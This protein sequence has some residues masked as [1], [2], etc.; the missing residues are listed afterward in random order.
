VTTRGIYRLPQVMAMLAASI[1]GGISVLSGISGQARAQGTLD[2]QYSIS[3]GGIPFGK[4]AWR[5]DVREDQFTATLSGATTGLLQLFAQGQGS[6]AVRGT[7]SK[8]EPRA[9]TYVSSIQTDKKYDE[10]RMVMN[11]NSV[12]E[13]QA[14]PPTPPSPSRIP[15]T[16]AHRRGV[17]D[18]MTAALIRVPGNGDVFAPETCQR[19]QA[20]FDGRMRYELRLAYKRLDRVRSD[21]GYQGAAVVCSVYFSPVAGYV[22]ER[23]VIKYLT[24]MRDAE[25]ALAPVAGTRLMVPFRASLPTPFGMGVLQ[26]TQ[27]NTIP[28]PTSSGAVGAKTQ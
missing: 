3:L 19:K 28:H 7:V 9:A 1:V 14:E 22:P 21:K 11:G 25:V 4:G 16:E 18:P 6:S 17:S 20:V 8:G 24:D 2:A 26:A 5:I 27:F 15:L 10:V 23:A 12:K 13:Y